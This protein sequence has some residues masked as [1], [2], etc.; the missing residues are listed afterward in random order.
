MRR[1][2]LELAFEERLLAGI[3]ESLEIGGR[4]AP[5]FR[6]AWIVEISA[7][8]APGEMH[9]AEQHAEL[10]AL[11]RPRMLDRL[12]RQPADERGGLAVQRLQVAVGKIGDRRR[13]RNA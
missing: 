4:H 13:A 11:G 8:G 9:A 12:A 2:E 5:P 3:E 1:L 7:V 6:P 10:R